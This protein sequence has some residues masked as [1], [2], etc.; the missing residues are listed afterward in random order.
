MPQCLSTLPASLRLIATP[1]R[2]GSG[3]YQKRSHPVNP[4]SFNLGHPTCT[5]LRLPSVHRSIH[6][7]LHTDV[8]QMGQHYTKGRHCVKQIKGDP[9]TPP[10]KKS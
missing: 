5:S 4:Q 6:P 2:R 3:C 10:K 8:T 1:T 7:P 9:F